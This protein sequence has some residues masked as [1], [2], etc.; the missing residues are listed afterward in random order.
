MRSLVAH[1]YWGSP[2]GGQ[3]V[4]ASVTLTLDELGFRP[5]LAGTFRLD[6]S[7]YLDWYGVDLNRYEIITLP[8]GAR[9]FG[10]WSRLFVWYPALKAVKRWF[11]LGI[12]QT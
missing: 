9:A 12:S 11:L 7:R 3:L 10:L 6:P 1:H 4:C 5:V 2:G 8:F